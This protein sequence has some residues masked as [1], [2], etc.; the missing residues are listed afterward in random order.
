M[1]FYQVLPA[2]GDLSHGGG[3]GG[4]LLLLPLPT[5]P[6]LRHIRRGGGLQGRFALDIGA[7]CKVGLL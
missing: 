5:L 3:E 7:G 6:A 1:P 2:G 4:E